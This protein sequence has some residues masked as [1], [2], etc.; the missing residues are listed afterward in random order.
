VGL[1]AKTAIL[2]FVMRLLCWYFRSRRCAASSVH[3][4]VAAIWRTERRSQHVSM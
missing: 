3:E 1:T 2:T 4:S